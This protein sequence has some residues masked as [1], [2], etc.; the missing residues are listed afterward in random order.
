MCVCSFSSR[1]D[2]FFFFLSQIYII[3]H[4]YLA[5]GRRENNI[6]RSLTSKANFQFMKSNK[7]KLCR[8]TKRHSHPIKHNIIDIEGNRDREKDRMIKNKTTVSLAIEMYESIRLNGTDIL[9]HNCDEQFGELLLFRLFSVSLDL[10]VCLLVVVVVSKAVK[11]HVY[12]A[13]WTINVNYTPMSSVSCVHRL[14][15]CDCVCACLL[16]ML[17]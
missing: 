7:S 6:E 15:W 11:F 8:L 17:L 3:N 9:T 10:F 12:T 5:E 13:L 1:L 16:K 2:E 4:F 14:I